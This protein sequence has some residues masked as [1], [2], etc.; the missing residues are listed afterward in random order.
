MGFTQA[1]A[2][3]AISDSV[4][5]ATIQECQQE[6]KPNYLWPRALSSVGGGISWRLPSMAAAAPTTH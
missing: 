2:A 1:N 4:S 5:N 6:R 3:S